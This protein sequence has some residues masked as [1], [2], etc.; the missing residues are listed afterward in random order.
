MGRKKTRASIA[1]PDGDG[2]MI[3]LSDR[4]FERGEF[5]D[6]REFDPPEADTWLQYLSREASRRGLQCSGISQ[7][8]TKENSGSYTI[9]SP[10]PNPKQEMVIV[11]ERKK[12]GSLL[13]R[14]RVAGQPE[15]DRILA[16]ELLDEATTLCRAGVKE[17]VYCVGYIEYSGLP[18][19]GEHWLGPAMR[20]GRPPAEYDEALIGP[21]AILV[22]AE[23]EGV[24][25]ADARAGFA[26]QLREL[27]AF[28][29]VVLRKRFL[30]PSVSQEKR[31]VWTTDDAWR[32]QCDVRQIG[33]QSPAPR[34]ALPKTGLEPEMPAYHITRP[35]LE[36]RGVGAGDTEQQL[37]SDFDELW[38]RFSSLPPDKRWQFLRVASLWQ[39]SNSLASE[40]ETASLAYLVAACEALKPSDADQR[41]NAYDVIETLLGKDVADDLRSQ[42]KP[43]LIR[44]GHFHTGEVFGSEFKK[45]VMMPSFQD[46]T[47][48]FIRDRMWL[49]TAACI[50]EW[51]RNDGLIAMSTPRSNRADRLSRDSRLAFAFVAGASVGWAI[52]TLLR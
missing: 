33:Y 31:W 1:I 5:L 13:V 19:R 49:V 52:R 45:L 28:I 47:F 22:E 44:H 29:G 4:R 8:D 30:V 48:R 38:S 3:P 27:S 7:I 51:L 25:V 20:L 41:L 23:V 15:F 10:G 9:R 32:I 17:R 16:N 6:S 39:L 26:V 50:I 14:P 46:P 36:S 11:W 42:W 12:K 43:M 18:W 2:G 37:P 34:E 21:R 35:N 24:D 40:F